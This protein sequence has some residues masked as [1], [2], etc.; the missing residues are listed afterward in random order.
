MACR[1]DSG[2]IA[3]LLVQS[4]QMALG[5]GGANKSG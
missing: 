4:N 3:G 5:L 2:G 1:L